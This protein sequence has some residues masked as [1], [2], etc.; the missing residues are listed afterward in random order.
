M[1]GRA[2]LALAFLRAQPASAAA[3]LEQ[4]PQEAVAAFIHEVPYKHAANV[5][6]MMLPHYTARLLNYLDPSVCAA[7]LSEMEVSH[8]AAILRYCHRDTK[9]RV[10]AHLPERIK[11]ECNLLLSYPE[12]AVGAWMLTAYLCLPDDCTVEEA[13]S[14]LAAADNGVNLGELYVVD[15]ERHP[16]G[17]VSIASLY[18]APRHKAITAVMRTDPDTVS[19]RASLISVANHPLWQR[20]ESVAVIN[21]NQQLV[22]ILRHL[23]LRAGLDSIATTITEPHDSEPIT[24]IWDVY[25]SCLIAIFNA[26]G[27]A[28]SLKKP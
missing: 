3:V 6:K 27:E 24:A 26:L 7:F 15:R 28:V 11:F 22:G 23:D 13:Q 25:G 20:V 10:F 16:Q 9:Q 2:D 19:G 18:R 21:R 12:T 1:S 14:R 4:Q 5:L 17:L 8:I